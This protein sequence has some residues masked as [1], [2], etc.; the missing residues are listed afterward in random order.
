MMTNDL[1]ISRN[2]LPYFL[3]FLTKTKATQAHVF[4]LS[5]H[6]AETFV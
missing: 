6:F 2:V 1:L 5:F 4:L 3:V